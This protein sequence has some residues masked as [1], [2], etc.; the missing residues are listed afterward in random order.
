[1]A[2]MLGGSMTRAALWRRGGREG[3]RGARESA[4]RRKGME[5]LGVD[6]GRNRLD[7]S[8]ARVRGQPG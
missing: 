3:S 1:M 8:G 4:E 7:Y 5:E 6:R 2:A